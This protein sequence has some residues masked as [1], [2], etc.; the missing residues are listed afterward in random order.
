MSPTLKIPMFLA[1]ATATAGVGALAAKG[2]SPNSEESIS[3]LLSKDLSK[4]LISPDESDYWTQSWKRYKEN[5]DIWNLRKSDSGVPDIFK[6]TCNNKLESKVSGK[7]SQGY[8]DFLAYCARDTLVSDL[9]KEMAP[10]KELI[11]SGSTAEWKEAWKKYTSNSR[12]SKTASSDGIWK[13]EDWSTQHSQPDAPTSFKTKCGSKAKEPSF[14]TTDQLYLD[15]LE[16]CTKDK[17]PTQA[18][19]VGG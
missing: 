18:G 14:E 16:F 6:T 9:I 3:S 15:V 4:R 11:P 5:S 10:N 1:G 2:L 7:D 19:G 17:T 12:N 13:I 8:K